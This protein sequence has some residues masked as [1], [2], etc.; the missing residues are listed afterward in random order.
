[1]NEISS[2]AIDDRSYARLVLPRLARRE[3]VR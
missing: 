2:P 3:D 1:M